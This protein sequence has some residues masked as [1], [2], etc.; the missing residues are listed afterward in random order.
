MRRLFEYGPILN[1]V[2]DFMAKDVHFESTPSLEEVFREHPRLIVALNHGTPLS[3]LP[4]VS[5]LASRACEF[6][7]GDRVP[8]GVMDRT[9][10]QIP[11]VRELAHLL[12]QAER[13]FSYNELSE[14]F[15]E[16]GDI[17]LVVF[18]EG[19]NC[20][21]GEPQEIQ[22]FRSPKF[23]ELAIRT[24]VPILIG[25]HSGSEK[26]ARALRIPEEMVDHL[27][28]LPQFAF[29]FIE[30][31][32]RKTGLFV[33]PLLPMPMEKFAMRVELYSPAL[34]FEELSSDPGIRTTQVQEEAERVRDRMRA[35][36]EEIRLK[37][38]SRP[39]I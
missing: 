14:R 10:F 39:P 33:L 30:K 37:E 2:M 5:L 15:S 3:W 27:R 4:A 20:F 26:W 17:D 1:Q 7:G 22:E 8:L 21:F 6:G 25:V 24:G 9:F 35:I 38:D 34:K 19:S 32:V 13:A 18:P 29:D 28:I 16:R 36:L 11:V 23:V 12:T 31:R